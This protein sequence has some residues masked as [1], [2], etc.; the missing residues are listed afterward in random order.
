[1]ITSLNE[2]KQTLLNEKTENQSY[3]YGCIMGYFDKPFKNVDIDKDDIYDNDDKEY[4]LEI[5]PHCTLLY[6]ILDDK[7]EEEEILDLLYLINCPTVEAVNI[8]VFEND[9]YD[10]VKFDVESK[11]LNVLNKVIESTFDNENKYPDYHAHST[12]AYCKK[13]TGKNY[14]EEFKT[15]ISTPIKYQIYSK[16]DGKKIKIIP[17]KEPEIIKEADLI[18]ENHVIELPEVI[19]Y[20]GYTLNLKKSEKFKDAYHCSAYLNNEYK[21]GLRGPSGYQQGKDAM[22]RAVEGDINKN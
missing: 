10:V 11:Y 2:F 14:K 12:I 3:S 16:A 6:G 5:E 1:M 21:F 19:H 18:K 15:P 13:G 22:I 7:V 17:G 20:K 9:E 8:S 4:G